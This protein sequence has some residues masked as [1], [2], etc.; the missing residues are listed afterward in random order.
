[1]LSAGKFF[2]EFKDEN[3]IYTR[4]I[5]I[6][7]KLSQCRGIGRIILIDGHLSFLKNHTLFEVPFAAIEIV[8]PDGIVVVIDDCEIIAERRRG[9]K[10]RIREHL[11]PDRL[12]QWQKLECSLASRYAKRLSV[13]CKEVTASDISHFMST[14]KDLALTA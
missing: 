4:Q 9:D 7:L 2:N 6:A 13:P 10:N 11:E 14:I 5:K 1:V 3:D 8:R 12:G